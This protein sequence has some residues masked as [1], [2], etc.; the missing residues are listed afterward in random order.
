MANKIIIE[1]ATTGVTIAEF[2]ESPRRFLKEIKGADGGDFIING[3]TVSARTLQDISRDD[4]GAYLFRGK[5]ELDPR[6]PL[7]KAKEF[8][9]SLPYPA[10]KPGRPVTMDGGKPVKVYLGA[11]SLEQ[12][13]KLGDGC[14]SL[15]I[16]R[17]LELATDPV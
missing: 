12:A 3:V 8:L 6:P 15:G 1:D 9:A 4:L 2:T 5:T 13:A 16:R 10:R 17:A 7:I 14:V 11:E